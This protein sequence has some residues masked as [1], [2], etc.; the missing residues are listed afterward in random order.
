MVA[1]LTQIKTGYPGFEMNEI[2]YFVGLLLAVIIS[3]GAYMNQNLQL[4]M[5]FVGYQ[6]VCK[7]DFCS[8]KVKM[9]HIKQNMY[10]FCRFDEVSAIRKPKIITF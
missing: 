10:I 7:H 1:L 6:K 4:E 5:A 2:R 3:R 8:I 9:W